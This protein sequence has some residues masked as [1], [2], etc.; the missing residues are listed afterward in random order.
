[1]PP[2][3]A[4]LWRASWS[5][6]RCRT[7]WCFGGAWRPRK[8]RDRSPL[9]PGYTSDLRRQLLVQRI[10]AREHVV[11]LGHHHGLGAMLAQERGERVPPLGGAVQRHDAGWGRPA[12]RRDHAE[13]LLRGRQQRLVEPLEPRAH[14]AKRPGARVGDDAVEHQAGALART[15]A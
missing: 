1:P 11:E 6:S 3:P 14:L 12:V 10:V 8:S 7:S 15:L 4:P 2:R 13:A 5:T 9:D